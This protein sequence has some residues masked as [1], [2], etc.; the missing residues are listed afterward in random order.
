MKFLHE[1]ML[2]GLLG[3][4]IPILIHWLNRARHQT[5]AFGGMMFVEA[6]MR[7]RAKHI[8][9]QDRLLLA[10]R[11]AIIALLALAAARPVSEDVS[12]LGA[13]PVATVLIVDTSLSMARES[14][15]GQTAFDEL[16]QSALALVA[17]MQA[18]D[19]MSIILAGT[20]PR[21]LFPEPI[22]DQR[23]L[24]NTLTSLQ[25]GYGKADLPAALSQS[26]FVLSNSRRPR[27][28]IVLL[29]DRQKANWKAGPDIHQRLRTERDAL[30]IPPR[31]YVLF[32]RPA[33]DAVN[34]SFS[35]LSS[36]NPVAHTALPNEISASIDNPS[37]RPVSC[38]VRFQL[39][40]QPA[41]AQDLTL[42]PGQTQIVFPVRHQK[43]GP[44]VARFELIGDQ[45]NADNLAHLALE[46][47]A[48]VPVLVVR[49]SRHE[50]LPAAA[51]V[52]EAL[53]S[54]SSNEPVFEIK[55]VDFGRFERDLGPLLAQVR[56]VILTR[57]PSLSQ[58]SIFG[59]EQFV[60][61][62]GGLVLS[63]G[64]D[65]PIADGARLFKDGDGLLAI[66]PTAIHALPDNT[67][68]TL[69]SSHIWE[70]S[71]LT[72][73]AE[74]AL[75]SHL[76]IGEQAGDATVLAHAGKHPVL[77]QRAYGTGRVA[78][79][80]TTLSNRWTNLPLTPAYLPIL[81]SVVTELAG[82]VAPPI[83]I[84][85]DTS[86][87]YRTSAP[88]RP[89]SPREVTIQHPDGKSRIPLS[90]NADGW[91]MVYHQTGSPG[92]YWVTPDNQDLPA[93]AYACQIDP[94]E[95]NF[96]S[97]A[98]NQW[99]EL[100]ASFDATLTASRAG[101]RDAI[102][103]EAQTREWWKLLLI[104]AILLLCVELA[105]GGRVSR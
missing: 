73:T 4:V 2:W 5:V 76:V 47:Q 72:R 36:R 63:F 88:V 65:D 21:V 8:K 103:A 80:T 90:L 99:Q 70:Q 17:D 89:G 59:L 22:F 27:R 58:Y 3:L 23:L 102:R 56:V 74:G 41:Q 96:H 50:S 98:S 67:P 32:A 37:S 45:F 71:G 95:S 64:P 69:R 100:S 1:Q 77:L 104:A 30:T 62:G 61:R 43:P 87:T 33:I 66:Q 13:Q 11:C 60:Q 6:S 44:A 53:Q 79:F 55:E 97:L 57:L 81:Y 18:T 46:V 78:T 20:T 52:R 93:K 14:R 19:S 12:A 105:V 35:Q 84:R 86:F 26:Y 42:A 9:L 10:L 48:T 40:D 7:L 101:L 38:T 75:L 34:L 31:Q 82:V 29:T 85:V 25:P 15:S 16:R 94:E 54:A 91:R 49:D 24:R 92:A 68:L 51:F 83:N 28:R 39:A